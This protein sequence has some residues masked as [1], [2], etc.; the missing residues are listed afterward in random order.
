MAF[1]WAREP[2]LS[3]TLA[4]LFLEN[5][6]LPADPTVI[7]PPSGLWGTFLSSLGGWVSSEHVPPGRLRQ[8]AL[9]ETHSFATNYV[10]LSRALQQVKAHTSFHEWLMWHTRH[11]WAEHTRRLGGFFDLEFMTEIEAI[12]DMTAGEV[13][14]LWQRTR[15]P[16]VVERLAERVRAGSWTEA[17]AEA[18]DSWLIATLLRGVYHDEL[19]RRRSRQNFRHPVRS[20]MPATPEASPQL[21]PASSAQRYFAGI[22]I[23]LSFTEKNPLARSGLYGENLTRCRTAIANRRLLLGED[24][25]EMTDNVGLDRAIREAQALIKADVLKTDHARF[26][27]AV[28]I[29]TG[30]S[31]SIAGFYLSPWAAL[32]AGTGTVLAQTFS[33]PGHR[34][35]QHRA[36]SV[37]RLEDLARAVA[38]SVDTASSC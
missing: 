31:A 14:S 20:F 21:F 26:S 13:E 18:V 4:G 11:E 10:P 34:L 27:R 25:L 1:Q 9:D 12:T 5:V 28:D 2:A 29:A 33:E 38:G 16:S 37:R 15:D 19:A 23:G 17:D 3:F 8:A 35:A 24:A 22:V 30:L 32:V 36:T 7:G 6:V